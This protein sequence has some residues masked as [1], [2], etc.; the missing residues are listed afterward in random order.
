MGHV[1]LDLDLEHAAPAPAP[2]LVEAPQPQ[3]GGHRRR[4]RRG[5]RHDA[6]VADQHLEHLG[7][8]LAEHDLL[9]RPEDRARREAAER[10]GRAHERRRAPLPYD[11]GGGRGRGRLGRAPA[12]REGRRRGRDRGRVRRAP[13][14]RVRLL[15]AHVRRVR[16]W[17]ALDYYGL[18]AP[19]PHQAQVRRLST[20]VVG[21]RVERCGRV[22]RD[23]VLVC[24]ASA[25]SS[26]PHAEGRGGRRRRDESPPPHALGNLVP[27]RGHFAR[28]EGCWCERGGTHVA[29]FFID[30]DEE[31]DDGGDTAGGE[32][33]TH[34]DT[35]VRR[36]T[37]CC[38]T[39]FSRAR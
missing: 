39:V 26:D 8:D 15:H 35:E 29:G 19:E 22:Q 2:A 27:Q 16:V 5:L 38:A 3:P 30:D 12:G 6:D 4:R 14:V 24:T 18:R 17:D 10:D 31:A 28:G 11:G 25:S 23:D 13:R 20:I 36:P 33:R 34:R 32:G 9:P 21:A 37:F 7:D 1:D